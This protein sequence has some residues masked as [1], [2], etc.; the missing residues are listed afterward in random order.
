MMSP[1]S[2]VDVEHDEAVLATSAAAVV[3]GD[4]DALIPIADVKH[5]KQW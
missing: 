5:E 3:D 2:Y 1:S 4:Q